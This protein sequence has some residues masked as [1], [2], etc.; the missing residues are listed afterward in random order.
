MSIESKKPIRTEQPAPLGGHREDHPAYGMIGASRVQSNGNSYLTGS[1]FGHHG[2]VSIEIHRAHLHRSTANDH[3]FAD[4]GVLKLSISEA[5]WASFVSTM[6]V[7]HGVPCTLEWTEKDGRVPL[8]DPI[9]N[10]REQLNT[11][12]SDRLGVALSSLDELIAAAPNKKLRDMAT[13]ARMQLSSNIPFIAEQFD[14]HA[15]KTVERAKS[16]VEAFLTGAIQRAGIY[17]LSGIQPI[18]MIEE[19]KP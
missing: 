5:Q 10:R 2:Y 6:N 14:E 7:G 16:E 17:A 4:G 3:W 8:I 12:V 1:D 18:S 11:E 15:E 9:T 13:K 19:P